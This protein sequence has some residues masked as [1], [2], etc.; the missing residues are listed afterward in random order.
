MGTADAHANKRINL[1]APLISVRRH[2]GAGAEAPATA[3]PAYRAD[4]TSGPLGHAGAVP[5]GWEH[6]PGHPKSV[7]T[8]RPPPPQPPCLTAVDEP[9]HAAREPTAVI[10]SSGRARDQERCSDV[11]DD[12]SCVT[13]N[14]SAAGLSDTASACSARGPGPGASG[15]VMMDRF[16]PAAHAVAA[17]SPQN[18]FRK[19]GYSARPAVAAPCARGGGGGYRTPAQRRL[20]FRGIPAYQY[21]L[22]PLSH[23]GK[24]V[25]DDGDGDGDGAESDAHSTAGFASRRCGLLPTRCVKGALLLS[26]GGR[27][28]AG[29][30]FLSNGDGR[31]LKEMNPLQRCSRNGQQH[32]GDDPGGA[33]SWEEVYIKSLLRSGGGGGG[34]LMGPA[35]AVASELDRTVRELYKR[36][37]RT[38]LA[39]TTARRR[40][41]SPEPA[42]PRRCCRRRLPKKALRTPRSSPGVSTPAST[43]SRCFR[44]T[45]RPLPDVSWRCVRSRRSRR[46]RCPSRRRSRGSRA[47]SLPCPLGPRRRLFWASMCSPRNTRRRRGAPL[48]RARTDHDRQ[49]Q[50]RVHDLQK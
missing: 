46:S 6:R 20:P 27:R 12:V 26:H 10:V 42:I 34:G 45:R 39:A 37:G 32:T 41:S 44:E 14:C 19:A 47:R 35:A 7:R 23:D 13:A 17:R 4:A 30:T 33:M 25:D 49:R 36:R 3:L 1:A 5:F 40:E 11:R 16:L 21:H 22:P 24:N 18:T 29:R 31:S 43:A 50:I 9:P 8:R 2:A 38:R 15:S 48:I 28:A